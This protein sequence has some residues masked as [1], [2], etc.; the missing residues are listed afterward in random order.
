MIKHYAKIGT[1]TNGKNYYFNVPY[2]SSDKFINYVSCER[3]GLASSL[4][5]YD[6]DKIVSTMYAVQFHLEDYDAWGPD[7]FDDE[8]YKEYVFSKV[9]G[10]YVLPTPSPQLWDTGMGSNWSLTQSE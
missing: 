7:T 10:L 9:R 3:D 6:R 8:E 4:F 2:N 1:M 5:G